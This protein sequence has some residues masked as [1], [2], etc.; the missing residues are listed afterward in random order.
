MH[1]TW[2]G[3]HTKKN[4]IGALP[5]TPTVGA[6]TPLVTPLL[7]PTQ[8][9]VR[10]ASR[11]KNI[12]HTQHSPTCCFLYVGGLLPPTMPDTSGGELLTP[13]HHHLRAYF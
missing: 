4:F 10:G 13:S 3:L 1:K 5:W 2:V 6:A 11:G 8:R 12:T 7:H 9:T